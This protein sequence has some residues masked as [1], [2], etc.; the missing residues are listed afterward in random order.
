MQVIFVSSPSI[1]G[2]GIRAW[3]GGL[4]NHVG[5]SFDGQTVLDA[6]FAHGVRPWARDEWLR[7][8]DRKVVAEFEVRLPNVQAAQTWAEMQFGQTY[9]WPGF[10]GF[11]LLRSLHDHDR[12]GDGKSRQYCSRYVRTTLAKGEALTTTERLD[13]EGRFAVRH[14]LNWCD[15]YAAGGC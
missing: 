2:A 9:D 4:P 5:M 13:R 6:T 8:Q 3:E 14:L 15:G 7:Y 11:P 1:A 10:V 12:D